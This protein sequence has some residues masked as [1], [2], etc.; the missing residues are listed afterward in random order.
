[1]EADILLAQSKAKSLVAAAVADAKSVIADVESW[2]AATPG[3]VK[4]ELVVLEAD[5]TS[6]WTKIKN[7]FKAV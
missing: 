7:W 1:M 5:L 3:E 4:S 2:V 6:I